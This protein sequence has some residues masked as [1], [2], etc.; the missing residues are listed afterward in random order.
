M[1]WATVEQTN[2]Y[3]WNAAKSNYYIALTSRDEGERQDYFAKTFRSVGQLMHLVE[4]L[5]SPPHVRNDP[6]LPI[7]DQ[8]DLYEEYTNKNFN[9]FSYTGY[10]VVDLQTFNS[11]NLFWT[12]NGKGL[13]E[14]T[15]S[16]FLS[17]DTN[18]GSNTYP[19]P[20]P[21]GV[22][23]ATETITDTKK[24]SMHVNVKYM[25][26]NVFDTYQPSTSATIKRLAAYS[27]L[28]AERKRVN[29]TE[30]FTLNN[31][32]LNEYAQFLLPRAVGY[33]A[34]LLNLIKKFKE[35]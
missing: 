21:T 23:V 4:D 15:N 31:A 33:S 12:N 24:R 25:Q 27:Y 28:D 20:A 7:N 1:D 5:A 34:G 14:F 32:V 3:G 22:W 18:F 35:L 11:T 19:A 10:P 26:G 13:A 6:H 29:N 9:S 16:N 17:R 30:A 8:I 2:A